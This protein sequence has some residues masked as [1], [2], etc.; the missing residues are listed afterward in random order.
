[1]AIGSMGGRL[2]PMYTPG[3]RGGSGRPTGVPVLV[4]PFESPVSAF[5][6]DFMFPATRAMPGWVFAQPAGT[7]GIRVD[8]AEDAGAPV[9]ILRLQTGT[10]SGNSACVDL[11]T[12]DGSSSVRKTVL[13]LAGTP[14]PGERALAA[15]RFRSVNAGNASTSARGVGL[16]SSD[17]AVA[18][19]WW[20][21]PDVILAAT[22]GL[23]V[24]RHTSAYSG[25]A[26]GDLVFRWYDGVTAPP[27]SIT[28]LAAASFSAGTW[29]DV[30]LVQSGT[31]VNVLLNGAL[32][33]SFTPDAS[34]SMYLSPSAGI[35]TTSG[36]ARQLDVDF[37]YTENKL[38]AAR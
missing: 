36:A 5:W 28:L 30:E 21:D 16:V 4:T 3:Q 1:M 12:S 25:D 34:A 15:F 29:Y 19:D 20:S 38:V 18:T 11:L 23:V 6:D 32:K 35:A 13:F 2:H 27:V 8:N 14:T 7:T 33:G 17:L 31:T 37:F 22:P 24:T 10:T 26:T 9:G